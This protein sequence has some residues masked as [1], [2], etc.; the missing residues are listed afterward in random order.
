MTADLEKLGSFDVVLY[1]GVLYHL[2]NPLLALERLVTLTGEVAIIE[3]EAIVIPGFEHRA[4]CEF[5]ET[6][7]LAD[8]PS[9]WWAPNLTALRGMCRAAGFARV[10]VFTEPPRVDT[11]AA[12]DAVHYRAVLHA[13]R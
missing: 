11:T 2:R 8:D 9:N 7:E 10:E 4:F 1:L 13:H 3:S 5:Y 12:R 6:N